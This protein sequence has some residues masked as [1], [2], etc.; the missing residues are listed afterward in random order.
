M[1]D[2]N[3]VEELTRIKDDTYGEAEVD[4]LNQ[5]IA[6]VREHDK[7]QRNEVLDEAILALRC[8]ILNR[9][10]MSLNDAAVRVIEKL[11]Q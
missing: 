2:Y 10:G 8:S 9:A 5:A 3:L 1:S 4:I 6:V 11:K 7:K